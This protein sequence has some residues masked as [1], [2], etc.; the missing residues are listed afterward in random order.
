MRQPHRAAGR[1]VDRALLRPRNRRPVRAYDA[2]AAEARRLIRIA[3]LR[4]VWDV[5]FGLTKV[6]WIAV[7]RLTPKYKRGLFG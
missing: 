3:G 1:A 5:A 4:F 2:R 7:R 6:A